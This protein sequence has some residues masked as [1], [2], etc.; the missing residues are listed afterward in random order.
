[1]KRC[2]NSVAHQ[3]IWHPKYLKI[4][5]TRDI[6]LTF[7]QQEWYYLLCSTALFHSKLPILTTYISKCLSANLSLSLGRKKGLLHKQFN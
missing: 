1:M 6:N 7:G 5:V 4:K 3:H 2:L